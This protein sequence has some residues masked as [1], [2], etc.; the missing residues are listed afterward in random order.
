ME[1]DYWKFV[2]TLDLR[3]VNG[4]ANGDALGRPTFHGKNG[5]SVIDYVICDQFTL[6]SSY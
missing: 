3:I 2:K 5:T 4:R 6:L 1:N